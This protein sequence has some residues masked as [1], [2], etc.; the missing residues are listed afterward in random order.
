VASA[1]LRLQIA[2]RHAPT[3][4]LLLPAAAADGGAAHS[5]PSAT[6]VE[7]AQA[8]AEAEPAARLAACFAPP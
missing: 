7:A 3:S 5:P 4:Q 2:G 1:R 8:E 6:A